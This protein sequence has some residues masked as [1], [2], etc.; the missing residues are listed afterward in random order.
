MK[1]LYTDIILTC[2]GQLQS[3]LE[4]QRIPQNL[5]NTQGII[6]LQTHIY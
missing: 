2:K 5:F 1:Y 4:L 6:K 3:V